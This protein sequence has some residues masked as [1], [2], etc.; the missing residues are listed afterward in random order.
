MRCGLLGLLLVLLVTPVRA[1]TA[2]SG[3]LAGI[4]DAMT[5]YQAGFS[6]SVTD[7]DGLEL[8]RA[9]GTVAARKPGMLRWE[10]SSPDH[11]LIVRNGATLWRYEADLAQVTVQQFDER[12]AG[13]NGPAAVL[14]GN[15]ANVLAN[16]E[17]EQTGDG[18]FQLLAREPS[19]TFAR[20]ELRFERGV[21][22]GLVMVDGFG[23]TTTIQFHQANINTD[24][25]LSLFEFTI[26]DGADVYYHDG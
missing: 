22:R 6:Q 8:Q 2:A 7:S 11:Q 25:D 18:V 24:P 5:S 9:E 23:Q 10:I 3:V 26:P 16:Y 15:S 21:L 17:V 20:L 13:E 4:I 19:D 1:D 12:R 14:S